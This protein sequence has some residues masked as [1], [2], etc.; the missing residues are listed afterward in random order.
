M[1]KQT[2][3]WILFIVMLLISYWGIVV[4]FSTGNGPLA[5]V[6][7]IA[8]F[9]H[10]TAA[11]L[12]ISVGTVSSTSKL[13]SKK[14]SIPGLVLN[15]V[16]LLISAY[17]WRKDG[18]YEDGYYNYYDHAMIFLPPIL[19]AALSQGISFLEFPTIKPRNTIQ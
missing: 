10:L 1:K 4:F 3:I 9:A 17:S 16:G 12:F 15:V 11:V 6:G 18:M 8:P 14:F 7:I 13:R 5:A 2:V 19:F